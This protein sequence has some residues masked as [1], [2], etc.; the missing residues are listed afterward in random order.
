MNHN[1][2]KRLTF[3]RV[4]DNPSKL[5]LI[6]AKAA[7]SFQTEK[8][9]IIAVPSFEAAQY[10]DAL[11][12][13]QPEESFMP[14]VISDTPTKEWI[15]ITLQEEINVNQAP[16]LLNLRPDFPSL[17]KAVDH[18][19]DLYDETHPSKIELSENRKKQYESNGFNIQMR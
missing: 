8:R 13:R 10:I 12:W 16:I 6:C 5:R 3:F 11:L 2:T 17:A 14:H 4:K 7:E 18:V 19:Y 9:L 1:Q 15:A